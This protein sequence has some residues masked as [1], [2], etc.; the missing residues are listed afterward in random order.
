MNQ[1][2]LRAGL[3]DVVVLK[4]VV[5]LGGVVVLQAQSRMQGHCRMDHDGHPD[6]PGLH[7]DTLQQVILIGLQGACE[8]RIRED[9]NVEEPQ[10]GSSTRTACAAM[11]CLK[12]W[13]AWAWLTGS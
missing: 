7:V 1:H 13:S 5:Q 2:E 6:L 10:G 12:S 3:L 9:R 11:T 8:L 4:H